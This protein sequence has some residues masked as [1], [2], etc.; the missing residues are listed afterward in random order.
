MRDVRVWKV[1]GRTSAHQ[2]AKTLAAAH[3]L[4]KEIHGE[5]LKVE[6]D[7][8]DVGGRGVCRLLERAY[9]SLTRRAA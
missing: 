6:E 1:L 3:H 9:A 2:A 7:R 5:D 8:V 4:F